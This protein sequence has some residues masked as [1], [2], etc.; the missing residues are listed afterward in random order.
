MEGTGNLT[1]RR[2]LWNEVEYA[3]VQSSD[4]VLHVEKWEKPRPTETI[5]TATMNAI[6]WQQLWGQ[7]CRLL[8]ENERSWV[9]SI[10]MKICSPILKFYTR[11][12]RE[13]RGSWYEHFC[14]FQLQGCKLRRGYRGLFKP[15]RKHV[16]RRLKARIEEPE[17]TSIS[18]Q[19]L[20][21]HIPGATNTQATIGVLLSY[22]D[23]NG[24]FCWI[25]PEAI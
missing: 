12:D 19:L 21:K 20:G 5:Q 14:K 17:Q 3:A 2:A 16:I 4:S 9:S 15:D 18:R 13:R 25:R 23:G 10:F 11:R 8:I 24:V 1:P 22:N 7:H 6:V